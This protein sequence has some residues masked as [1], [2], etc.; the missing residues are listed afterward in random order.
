MSNYI[1][2][3]QGHL[4]KLTKEATTN[5]H[6]YTVSLAHC[7]SHSSQYRRL[8]KL[9]LF[10]ALPA[11]YRQIIPGLTYLQ[12][13]VSCVLEVA[14]A[15]T[16]G[17]PKRLFG[18]L[19]IRI[20]YADTALPSFTPF[21]LAILS[22]LQLSILFPLFIASIFALSISHPR[23]S[24]V[25]CSFTTTFQLPLFSCLKFSSRAQHSPHSFEIITNSRL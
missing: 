11:L 3:L 22:F 13:L 10:Q 2:D 8:I 12:R 23:G 7:C 15:P 5:W 9:R 21:S 14:L 19:S 16:F 25:S 1:K 4:T 20:L 6:R 24:S 17:L 18:F